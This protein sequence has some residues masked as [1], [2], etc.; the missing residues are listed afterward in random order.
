MI[1]QALF[2]SKDKIKLKSRL[3][4]FSLGTLRARSACYNS[5]GNTPEFWKNKT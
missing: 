2:S 3:L 5:Y 1:H 4:Q